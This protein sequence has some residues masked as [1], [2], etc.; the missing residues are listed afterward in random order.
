M[1]E[2][3]GVGVKYDAVKITKQ[4]M[5]ELILRVSTNLKNLIMRAEKVVVENKPESVDGGSC[6]EE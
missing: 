5:A 3:G 6:D 1:E 4:V 2:V